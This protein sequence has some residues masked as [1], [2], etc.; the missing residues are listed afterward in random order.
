MNF[1]LEIFLGEA[2]DARYLKAQSKRKQ[3]HR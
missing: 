1:F 3:T 2:A